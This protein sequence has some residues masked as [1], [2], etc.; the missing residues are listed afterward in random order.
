MP[1]PIRKPRTSTDKPRQR[2]TPAA[3]AKPEESQKLHKVLAQAGVGSRRLME[4]WIRVGRVTVNGVAATIGAR[5]GSH[6]RVTVDGRP[7]QLAAE[8]TVRVLLYHK[9]DGEIVTRDDPG[10]RETVFSNLPRLRGAKWISVGRLDVNTSGLLIFTTSGELAN[11]M[12]HP[13]FDVE[14]EYAA[15]VFGQLMPEQVRSL[16]DGVEL[17]DG[18]AHCE[19]FSDAGGEGS[20]HWYR[21]V[22]KEGRNRL[23]RRLFEKLGYTV[24]RLIRV[25]FGVIELPS[26]LRRGQSVELS[27]PELARLT[28]WL[29]QPVR[30][31]APAS[32]RSS[33]KTHSRP[34]HSSKA[35]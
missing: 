1:S 5:V 27:A 25:R 16:Q 11:R 18:F 33:A 6:D 17:E 19:Q 4:D 26:Q 7:L 28:D 24:S 8:K 12:M 9:P 3:S 15:R 20:N 2:R 22:V 29:S 34:R 32:P 13:K 21:L 14:R 35:R 30:P 10:G 31:A 23:V